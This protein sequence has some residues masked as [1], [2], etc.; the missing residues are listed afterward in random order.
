MSASG[1]DRTRPLCPYPQVATVRGQRQHRPG[2][3]FPLR[4]RRR[5]AEAAA[6][7]GSPGRHA[8]NRAAATGSSDDSRWMA[9]KRCRSVCNWRL[10]SDELCPSAIRHDQR[11]RPHRLRQSWRRSPLVW[12][13]TSLVRRTATASSFRTSSKSPTDLSVSD[14]ASIRYDVRGMGFSDRDV[15]DLSLEG[16]VRDLTAVVGHLGLDRFALGGVDIGA[17]TAVAYAAAHPASVSHLILLSPWASGARY[18]AIPELRAANAAPS[19]TE[20]E[21]KLFVKIHGSV[22]LGFRDEEWVRKN[23]DARCKPRR[24]RVSSRSTWRRQAS[25]SPIFFHGSPY[26]RS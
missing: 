3:E 19:G 5:H 10:V 8:I 12:P 1:V 26:R 14:G 15:P 16:R 11:R 25:T 23:P 4:G 21:L 13:P 7:T 6:D 24:Q 18:L 20:R 9:A 22:A 17:A 2:R